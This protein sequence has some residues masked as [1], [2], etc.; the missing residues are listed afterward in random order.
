MA[1]P[2][3]RAVQEG[4]QPMERG[5]RRVLVIGVTGGVGEAVA[6]TLVDDGFEVYATCRN[7]LR[8]AELDSTGRYK[9]VVL[10]DLE[11]AAS[12]RKAFADLQ[13]SGV[14]SLS[15]VVNCAGVLQDAGPLEFVSEDEGDRLFRTTVFG[16]LLAIQLAIPLL[17]PVRGRIVWVSSLGGSFALP[18]VSLYC[19]SKHSVEAL[20]DGLRRELHGWGISVSLVKPSFMDTRM[21]H[22]HNAE[23]E[24][25]LAG[26]QVLYADLYRGHARAM[27]LGMRKPVT[28]AR[29]AADIMHAL[30]ARRPRARYLQ[31]LDTRIFVFLMKILPET[32]TDWLFRR[33]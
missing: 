15:G 24:K 19:A 14:D 13:A 21:I 29:V 26:P 7:P 25:E 18:M 12:I 3:Q 9:R 6:D 20:C 5:S 22:D 1:S 11:S 2:S 30:T 32:A 17:R 23:L 33:L 10:L 16:P 27:D 28:T 8:Q 4:S 31:G